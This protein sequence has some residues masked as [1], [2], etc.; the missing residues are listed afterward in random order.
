MPKDVK[1]LYDSIKR[2][3]QEEGIFDKKL[4]NPANEFIVLI[5]LPTKLQ[6]QVIKPNDRSFI[7]VSC[8][9]TISP[10]HLSVLNKSPA[11]FLMFRTEVM[12]YI[13]TRP[14]D[15]AFHPKDRKLFTIVD[16]IFLD[17]LTQHQFFSS[18]REITHAF[19]KI[20]MILDS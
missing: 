16:R 2:W 13:I 6:L 7:I 1:D 14:L 18:I 3:T 15:V 9:V 20:I 8:Q 12:D 4:T 19:Q 11:K 5:K 10:Q 17:G